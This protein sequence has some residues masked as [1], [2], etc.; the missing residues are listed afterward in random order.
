MLRILLILGIAFYLLYKIGSFFFRAGAAS[1][2]LRNQ[3]RPTGVDPNS[4]QKKA[5]HAKFKD[6]EYVDYEEIK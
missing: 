1:Q 5:T 4:K 3:K 2:Q 6:G